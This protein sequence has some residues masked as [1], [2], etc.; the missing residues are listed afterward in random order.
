MFYTYTPNKLCER[1]ISSYVGD[2]LFNIYEIENYTSISLFI[3]K[4]KTFSVI[5]KIK[6]NVRIYDTVN[7]LYYTDK[8]E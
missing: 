6:P 7:H 1:I 5:N 8:W 4:T 2:L 3:N